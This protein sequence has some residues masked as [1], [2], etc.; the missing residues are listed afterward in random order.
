MDEERGQRRVWMVPIQDS[1]EG[2]SVQTLQGV[3]AATEDSVG[4]ST[5]GD[6]KGEGRFTIRDLFADE[7]CTSTIL[8][9]LRT[10]KVGSR[11]GPS[12]AP[13][14][15]DETEEAEGKERGG[16]GRSESRRR[17]GGRGLGSLSG[18]RDGLPSFFLSLFLSGQAGRGQGE[19]PRAA[20]GLFEVAA[21]GE[22]ERKYI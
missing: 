7:P 20:G 12:A 2:T 3:E 15:P 21:D 4:G 9:F 1:D 6:R 13:P 19:L 8:D 18:D 14:K 17:A 5:K 10:T 22:Q 11:V 16:G